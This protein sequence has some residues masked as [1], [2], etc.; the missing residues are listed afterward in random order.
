MPRATIAARKSQLALIVDS[1]MPFKI[2]NPAVN[3]TCLSIDH[4]GSHCLFFA[5][6]WDFAKL[7]TDLPSGFVSCMIHLFGLAGK[8][9]ARLNN[10]PSVAD[11]V[12]DHKGGCPIIFR[13]SVNEGFLKASFFQIQHELR[14]LSFKT[15]SSSPGAPICVSIGN[16]QL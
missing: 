7:S 16:P 11:A 1:A 13:M 6:E 8:G 3:R 4:T 10:C 15:T 9:F 14:H 5:G 2:S 12:H